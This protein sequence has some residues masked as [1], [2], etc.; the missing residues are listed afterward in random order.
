MDSGLPGLRRFA[1]RVP[2]LLGERSGG[3]FSCSCSEDASLVGAVPGGFLIC[4]E[5]AHSA[6]GLS[7]FVCEYGIMQMD[8][9]KVY[10]T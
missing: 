5:D 7:P 4:F 8:V 1:T 2:M 6:L 3:M 10:G 9:S